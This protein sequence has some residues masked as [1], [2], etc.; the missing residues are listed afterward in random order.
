M[1]SPLFNSLL[2]SFLLLSLSASSQTA[3]SSALPRAAVSSSP[4]GNTLLA[5]EKRA[6]L[7][8]KE[9]DLKSKEVSQEIAMPRNGEIYLE[10]TSRN[11]QVKTWDQSK[12]KVTTTVYYDGET[13][14][15]DQ[16]WMAKL[17][18]TLKIVGSSVKVKSGD[19]I[20]NS[21]IYNGTNWNYGGNA[22][23]AVFSGSGENI[24]TKTNLKR[25]VTVFVPSDSKLDIETKYADV[26]IPA[27]INELIIDISNG[28][29][30]AD[31]LN[32][33]E[34]RSRYSNVNLADV[35]MAE[36]EFS[37][38]RF[39][40]NNID[41]LDIDTKYSS[42]EMASA[43]K[44]L[45]RSTIDEY[46]IEDLAEIKGIKNYGN[47]RITRLSGSIDLEGTNADVKVR[48]ILAGVTL[49]KIDN[50][51]ANIRMPLKNSKNYSVDFMGS[52]SQ[53]YGDFEK[54]VSLANLT[55]RNVP[56]NSQTS[57]I[58]ATNIPAGASVTVATNVPAGSN[59]TGTVN[60]KTI[61]GV[62]YTP[63]DLEPRKPTST[64][65]LSAP[66]VIQGY[67]YTPPSNSPS[68]FTATVGDGKGLKIDMKCQNCTIDFK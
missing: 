33:L 42:V 1:K 25:I 11:L 30:E 2:S 68:Q 55:A 67:P 37:N 8:Y 41:D 56:I 50:R 24:G 27:G 62:L 36:V 9:E 47:L 18:L 52:Y 43:K 23:V 53:V 63:A 58:V 16:E 7:N 65:T 4:S 15:S 31:N 5:G 17:N 29:L 64:G 54:K 34:M 40:A 10:S 48:N 35:K 59:V 51:Y 28:N 26:T 19:L 60:A 39:Y 44:I 12:I 13:K 6:R 20:N 46:E 38:G 3:P 66:K 57:A 49:I 45:L 22:G 61:E 14:L 21:Y 32:K